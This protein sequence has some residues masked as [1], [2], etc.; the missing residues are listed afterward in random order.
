MPRKMAAMSRWI[1][2]AT[3]LGDAGCHDME[4]SRRIDDPAIAG[5]TIALQVCS[6]CHGVN[7]VS[8]SPTFPSLAGQQREY[9]VN[10]LMD[11]R[12]HRRS[13]PNAKIYMWGFTHLSDAQIDELAA[14]FSS[15]PPPAGGH[16]DPLLVDNGKTIFVSGLPDK[17]VPACSSCHGAH[18]E[19]TGEF[20]RLAGQHADYIV[21]QLAIFQHTRQRP[22]GEVMSAI[23]VKL[24]EEEMHSVA[25]FLEASTAR[26]AKPADMGTVETGSARE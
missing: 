2:L 5:K 12:A 24:T 17:G 7:G 16:A 8:V 25:A 6:N 1:L 4:H 9:L 26:S 3:L 21:K 18:G 14:Y 13:D 10:Q 19:G 23:C 20:P 15:R 22:R 11:F